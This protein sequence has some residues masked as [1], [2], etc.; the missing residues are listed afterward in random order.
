MDLQLN[1][2]DLM[3]IYYNISM[4]HLLMWDNDWFL[5]KKQTQ[6]LVI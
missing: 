4:N 1:Y 5:E 2:H 6:K 3:K